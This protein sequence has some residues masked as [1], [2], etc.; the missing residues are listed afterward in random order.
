M[1]AKCIGSLCDIVI[2]RIL[3][4]YVV[5]Y[6]FKSSYFHLQHDNRNE[7]MPWGFN[8]GRG[9][10]GFVR[11]GRGNGGGRGFGGRA[12]PRFQNVGFRKRSSKSRFK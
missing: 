4:D 3:M 11:G 6:F 12:T 5:T 7:D 2:I 10:G 9:R 1:D 8:R